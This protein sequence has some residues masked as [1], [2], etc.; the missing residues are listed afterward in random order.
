M[1]KLPEGAIIGLLQCHARKGFKTK[2]PSAAREL[3]ALLATYLHPGRKKKLPD[4]ARQFLHEALSAMATGADPAVALLFKPP[5]GRPSTS[6]ED[7]SLAMAEEIHRSPL[8]RHK[9]DGGAYKVIGD[10][11]NKSPSAAEAAYM[12]WREAL[13]LEDEMIREIQQEEQDALD[14]YYRELQDE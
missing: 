12:K 7:D 13:V 6:Y 9:A 10:Q 5:R 3:A 1:A 4:A 11:F 8:G 2:D 14:R